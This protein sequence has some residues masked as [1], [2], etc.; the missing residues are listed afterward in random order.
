MPTRSIVSEKPLKFTREQIGE[1]SIRK[2]SRGAITVG[3]TTCTG[4]VGI[5][6]DRLI[7]NW[8]VADFAD[9]GEED[10]LPVIDH[11]PELVIVGCGWQSALPPRELVFAFSR[12]GIGLEIMDT[13][14]A[15]RTFNILL[16]EGR[17]PAA[18]LYV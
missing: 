6:P 13:P 14:A 8:P 10:L 5:L 17:R 18:V 7:L 15:C 1:F 11:N 16:G 2:I 9:L 12:R 4:N 3:E